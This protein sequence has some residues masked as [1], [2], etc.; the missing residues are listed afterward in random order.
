VGLREGNYAERAKQEGMKDK[1]SRLGGRKG[2]RGIPSWIWGTNYKVAKQSYQNPL[3]T[4]YPAQ[5]RGGGEV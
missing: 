5:T 1:A 2:R 3:Q 4:S